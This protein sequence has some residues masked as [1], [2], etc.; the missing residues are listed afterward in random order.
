MTKVAFSELAW[1][2]DADEA[3]P[4]LERRLKDRDSNAM[5]MLGLCCEY[6][7]GTAQDIE[8]AELLYR[9]SCEGGNFV[10]EFLLKNDEGG[11]GSGEMKVNKCL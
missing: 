7:L 6:G 9:E 4:L 1:L 11:R 8:R 10:G 5:W 2:R 3:D